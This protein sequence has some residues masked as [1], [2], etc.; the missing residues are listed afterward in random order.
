M[1]YLIRVWHVSRELLHLVPS[2]FLVLACAPIVEARFLKLALSLST[3]ASYMALS[4]VID[5]D[6]VK[7]YPTRQ[8]ALRSY[9]RNTEFGFVCNVLLTLKVAPWFKVKTQTFYVKYLP[10]TG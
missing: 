8:Y 7:Y 9:G 10:Y 5:N 2:P 6:C 1:E 4:L 3:I